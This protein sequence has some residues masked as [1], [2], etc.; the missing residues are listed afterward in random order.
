MD[1]VQEI[2]YRKM[3]V[4]AGP[5]PQQITVEGQDSMKG[6]SPMVSEMPK[7]HVIPGGDKGK[8]KK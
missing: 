2:N 7:K 1:K 4:P 6:G 5:G 8:D 3:P